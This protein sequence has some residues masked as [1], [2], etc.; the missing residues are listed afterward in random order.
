MVIEGDMKSFFRDSKEPRKLPEIA[1]FVATIVFILATFASSIFCVHCAEIVWA[2]LNRGIPRVTQRIFD[3][4]HMSMLRVIAFA[5][6]LS[7]VSLFFIV[8]KRNTIAHASFLFI[9]AVALFHIIITSSLYLPL[10]TF[11]IA[12]GT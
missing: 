12:D 6:L 7:Y 3:L 5:V 10:F 8:R 11:G 4:Y 1:Y 9:F 2:D